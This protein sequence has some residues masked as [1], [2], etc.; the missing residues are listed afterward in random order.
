MSTVL[1][2]MGDIFEGSAQI[3][4]LPCSGKGTV[5]SAIRRWLTMLEIPAPTEIVSQ[6]VFGSISEMIPF[7]GEK[8]I[9]ENIVFAASVLNDFSSFEIIK[10]IGAQLGKLTQVNTDIRVIE[11]PLLGTGAGGLK[12]EVA[13]KALYEGF[14]ST[15]APDAILY[16]F[17]FDSERQTTLQMLFN[18]LEYENLPM[19]FPLTK[20]DMRYLRVF[21]CHSSNDKTAVEKFYNFLQRDG[22]QAW[23]DKKN[24]V[25]GQDWRAEIQKAVINSHVVIVF[26]SS[27]SITREGFVQKEIKIALDMADEKPDGTIFIIPA[28]LE[29]C[30]VPDRLTKFHWVDLFEKDGYKYLI[31]ALQ[32][33]AQSLNINI[34]SN[35]PKQ[36]QKKIRSS[37]SSSSRRSL[38]DLRNELVNI[39]KSSYPDDAF[40]PIKTWIAKAM[41]IIRGEWVNAFADFNKLITIGGWTKTDMATFVEI[42]TYGNGLPNSD[43]HRQAWQKDMNEAEE[44]RQKL[45]NFLDGLLILPN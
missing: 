20:S 31:K 22:I 37:N 5:S 42:V 18:S 13:G 12:T 23:F 19:T 3:T 26:L 35:K 8:R 32:V 40:M 44:L 1:V 2:R 30:E 39:N 7:K 11:T 45:L 17:V 15:A 24:L 25:P 36:I 6:P 38:S 41:P 9:T 4:V 27:Q 29:N 43:T 28:K 16:V 34:Q 33:R 10:R 14:K 21:L